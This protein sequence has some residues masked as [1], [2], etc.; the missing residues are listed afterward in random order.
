MERAIWK[1][2]ELVPAGGGGGEIKIHRKGILHRWQMYTNFFFKEFFF[3]PPQS[4]IKSRSEI[5]QRKG[6]EGQ[7]QSQGLKIQMNFSQHQFHIRLF[8]LVLY[9]RGDFTNS[10][11]NQEQKR[12]GKYLTMMVEG[13]IDEGNRLGLTGLREIFQWKLVNVSGTVQ[14]RRQI[15]DLLC[16][17]MCLKRKRTPHRE[18]AGCTWFKIFELKPKFLR[19]IELAAGP[20]RLARGKGVGEDIAYRYKDDIYVYRYKYKENIIHGVS[21]AINTKHLFLRFVQDFEAGSKIRPHCTAT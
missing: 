11:Y 7:T 15:L 13:K 8:F 4:R 2:D 18:H 19:G 16:G 6:R 1:G 9:Q 10:S 14:D 21:L 3:F 20:K 12:S 5:R 17:M